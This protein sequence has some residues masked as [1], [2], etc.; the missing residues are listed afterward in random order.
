MDPFKPS[1][2]KA[3]GPDVVALMRMAEAAEYNAR[4][5]HEISTKLDRI[6]ALLEEGAK[7]DLMPVYRMVEE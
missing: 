2:I 3:V 5:M 6:I 1:D 4:G 7:P